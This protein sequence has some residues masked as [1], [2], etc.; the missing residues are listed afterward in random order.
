MMG[1]AK[2]G[3]RYGD[4]ASST[5]L[6]R[7]RREKQRRRKEKNGDGTSFKGRPGSKRKTRRSLVHASMK[8]NVATNTPGSQRKVDGGDSYPLVLFQQITEMPLVLFLKLLP[9]LHG[10]SKIFKNKSCSKFKVL[11]LCFNNHTLIQSTF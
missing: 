3:M 2:A 5:E 8:P 10:N 7:R 4:D 11:Q 1:F 9:K 6:W